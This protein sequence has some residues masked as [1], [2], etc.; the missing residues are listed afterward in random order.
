MYLYICYNARFVYEYVR[1]CMY[2]FV[3]VCVCL[4]LYTYVTLYRGVYIVSA[5]QMVSWT[6]AARVKS[7]WV[8]VCLPV[9]ECVYACVCSVCV[10]VFCVRTHRYRLKCVWACAGIYIYAHMLMLKRLYTY[11]CLY[12]YCIYS[13][14]MCVCSA[15]YV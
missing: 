7:V 3:C 5:I 2:V 15:I 13:V 10:C 6:W 14:Y 1:M 4:Y 12:V 8:R 11:I 9:C